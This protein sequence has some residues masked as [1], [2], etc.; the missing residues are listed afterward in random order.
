MTRILRK[1]LAA[2]RYSIESATAFRCSFEGIKAMRLTLTALTALSCVLLAVLD[3]AEGQQP[4]TATVGIKNKTDLTLIVKSFSVV[5]KSQ[6]PGLFTTLPKGGVGFDR[7][8]PA[9]NVRYYSVYDANQ[10][11]RPLIDNF[12][13]PITGDRVLAI[14][15]HPNNPK[16]LVI[17]PETP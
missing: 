3:S 16:M 17:V 2:L 11:V 10:P 14:V 9:N 1:C 15:P 4:Q 7:Q 5:N 6:K 12:G 8:V 13:V